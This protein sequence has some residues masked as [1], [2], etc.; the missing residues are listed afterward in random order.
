MML[1]FILGML[2]GVWFTAS[3]MFIMDATE[4]VDNL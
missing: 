4:E 2:A 1:Y 3:V